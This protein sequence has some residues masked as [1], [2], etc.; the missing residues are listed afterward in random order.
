MQ[1][2][3]DKNYKIKLAYDTT[4]AWVEAVLND[5]SSFLIDH[6]DCERKA[7]AMAMGMIY[8]APNRSEVVPALIET[9]L[10]EMVHFKQV[11]QLMSDRGIE[12]PLKNEK[13][14]YIADLMLLL[15]KEGQQRLLDR[16]LLAAIIETRGAE[17]FRLVAENIDDPKL[18]E[19]YT[20][21]YKSEDKHGNLFVEIALNYYPENEVFARL[22]DLLEEEARICA[23]LKPR[24][25]LH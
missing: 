24:A 4:E 22:E 19:Y 3:L 16:Y 21:L 2:H 13:D 1:F 12:L 9:A 25:A 11:Y 8:K 20:M 6:A 5:F 17:R 18:Q 15:R 14:P 10:E 23:A 7:S